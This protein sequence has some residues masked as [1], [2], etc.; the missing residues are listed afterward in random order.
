MFL[1]SG[2]NVCENEFLNNC[3]NLIEIDLKEG[4]EGDMKIE[5]G[6]KHYT[7]ILST[8]LKS[9]YNVTR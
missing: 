3:K 1:G 9:H 6:N 5:F 2:C 4:L 7:Q 8:T